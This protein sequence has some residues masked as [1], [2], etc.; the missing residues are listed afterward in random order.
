[1][2]GDDAYDCSTGEL[3]DEIK[4]CGFDAIV[5]YVDNMK[6]WYFTDTTKEKIYRLKKKTTIA[7]DEYGEEFNCVNGYE[8]DTTTPSV[9]IGEQAYKNKEANFKTELQAFNLETQYENSNDEAAAN[10]I[11]NTKKV[12]LKFQD[13]YKNNIVFKQFFEKSIWPYIRQV[14]PSTAIFEYIIP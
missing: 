6:V 11:I 7:E 8:E 10:S 13:N 5:E 12:V 3:L 4:N 14:I 2:F 9:L 1:M